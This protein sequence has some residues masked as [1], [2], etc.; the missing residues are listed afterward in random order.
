MKGFTKGFLLGLAFIAGLAI[1]QGTRSIDGTGITLY[2]EAGNVYS[3][4][5]SSGTVILDAGGTTNNVSKFTATNVLGDSRITDNADDVSM[6]ASLVISEEGT[7]V[8]IDL[9]DFG[10]ASEGDIAIDLGN[11]G[12]IRWGGPSI[13][14][15]TSTTKLI[16]SRAFGENNTQF[17]FRAGSSLY[18]PATKA[19]RSLTGTNIAIEIDGAATIVGGDPATTIL[20]GE[21]SGGGT[22]GPGFVGAFATE[23]TFYCEDS[24]ITFI[25]SD[26]GTEGQ[27]NLAGTAT[28]FTCSPGDVLK[29]VFVDDVIGNGTAGLFYEVSRSVN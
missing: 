11:T 18:G 3:F 16:F 28:N 22:F 20:T 14:M 8:G 17:L 19:Q 25:D 10:D 12:L 21:R 27:F 1:A 26:L 6:P 4:P 29:V 15:N 5:A 23:V 13:F 2:D 24:D 9:T 7:E